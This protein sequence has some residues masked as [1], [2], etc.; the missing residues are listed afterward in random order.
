ME[1]F[2]FEMVMRDMFF[3]SKTISYVEPSEESARKRWA[4][5]YQRSSWEL[6]AVIKVTCIDGHKFFFIQ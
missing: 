5:K 4:E 6:D 2:L 3:E 1:L